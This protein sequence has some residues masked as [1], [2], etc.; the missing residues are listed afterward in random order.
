MLNQDKNFYEKGPM[1]E[2]LPNPKLEDYRLTYNMYWFH[3]INKMEANKK[4]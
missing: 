3:F 2:C 4:V 1:T